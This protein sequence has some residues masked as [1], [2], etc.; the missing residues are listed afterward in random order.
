MLAP[1]GMPTKL[2]QGLEKQVMKIRTTLSK[3]LPLS[4]SQEAMVLEEDTIHK[5]LVS[6]DRSCSS[7]MMH[8]LHHPCRS[9]AETTRWSSL[10]SVQSLQCNAQRS[11]DVAAPADTYLVRQP[12]AKAGG[13]PQG[14]GWVMLFRSPL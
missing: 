12:D 2:V 8:S 13:H 6:V 4:A 5:S 11:L 1:H 10:E 7:Y 9:M 3:P 14:Q